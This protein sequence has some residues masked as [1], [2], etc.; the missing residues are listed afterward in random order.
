MDLAHEPFGR[1]P[2]DRCT[3]ALEEHSARLRSRSA[4]IE[5]AIVA[6]IRH[7]GPPDSLGS[8]DVQYEE[9]QRRAVA[10]ALNYAL[11]GIERGEPESAAIPEEAV[12]QAHRA[13]RS[14]VKLDT[15][16]R[17][18]CA[19]NAELTDFVTQEAESVGLLNNG[20]VLRGVQRVQGMLLDYLLVTVSNEYMREVEHVGRSPD[21]RRA[22][23]V[24][25]LLAGQIVHS[26]ELSYDLNAWHVAVIGTGLGVGQ[27]IR[28][29]AVGLDSRLLCVSY[30]DRSVWA[31]LGGRRNAVVGDIKRLLAIGWPTGICL[32]LGKPEQGVDGW[33]HTHW[34]AQDALLVALRQPRALTLYADVA[35]L[36][37]WVR[38]E[39]RAQWLVEM[40][41]SPLDNCGTSSEKLRTTLRAYYEAG[42]NASAAGEALNVTRR[43]IRNRMN[44]IQQR[45]GSMLTERQAE[46][47][48]ALRLAEMQQGHERQTLNGPERERDWSQR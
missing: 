48:L 20:A 1:Q 36:V 19:A 5:G 33:R 15:I 30:D 39:K 16:L 24:R 4:E 12:A 18:Y 46:L 44:V 6:R 28:G 40:Y 25:R 43:T 26:T 8:R 41:L 42:H 2:D 11:T 22:E 7:V 27:A 9:G 13:A 21:Q 47:E 38:D 45:L 35:F 17:R 34:Q 14:G 29:A 23:R 32:V 10:A 3:A 37:P 31:W